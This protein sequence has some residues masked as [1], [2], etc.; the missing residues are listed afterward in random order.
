MQNGSKTT[1]AIIIQFLPAVSDLNQ[2]FVA[3]LLPHGVIDVLEIIEVDNGNGK[4]FVLLD[5]AA[6]H[7]RSR[8]TVREAC[9]TVRKRQIPHFFLI[10]C[11]PADRSV[12][13]DDNDNHQ[14]I[15]ED[16]R[17]NGII[18]VND[19]RNE[20]GERS[21]QGKKGNI[22]TGLFIQDHQHHQAQIGDGGKS[23]RKRSVC[24]R[25]VENHNN[26]I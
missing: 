16:S 17:D 4:R 26:A 18:M 15:Y 19:P 10:L 24:D 14:A 6:H 8:K 13:D 9:Q 12:D 11:R 20:R 7:F 2:R 22:E 5:Q 21:R 1:A 23:S 3:G 25:L